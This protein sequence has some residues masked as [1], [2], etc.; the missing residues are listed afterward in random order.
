MTE[1]LMSTLEQDVLDDMRQVAEWATVRTAQ[2]F[3]TLSEGV[4]LETFTAMCELGDLVETLV[5]SGYPQDR[6]AWPDGDERVIPAADITTLRA[7]IFFEKIAR[8]R[9]IDSTE[10]V[11]AWAWGRLEVLERVTT[12]LDS[13]GIEDD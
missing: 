10:E 4:D 1:V 8:N 9:D 2:K 6:N 7:A 11:T 13:L 5:E 12:Y 3:S